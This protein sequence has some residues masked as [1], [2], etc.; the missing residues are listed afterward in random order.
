MQIV[1]MNAANAHEYAPSPARTFW[2]SVGS[3]TL[4]PKR[5]T[6]V[7]YGS[8]MG[9]ALLLAGKLSYGR[10]EGVEFASDLNAIASQ[11]IATTFPAPEDRARFRLHTLDATDYR[12]PLEPCVIY[13]FNP[14]GPM[15][16][17]RI[18]DI[19]LDS[20][21]Q[22]PRE[23]YVVY[24]NPQNKASFERPEFQ[25]VEGAWYAKYL[26]RRVPSGFAIYRLHAAPA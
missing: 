4:D 26:D 11:N 7:D 13:L 5:F 22:A 2:L 8:G 25:P 19:I 6:F 3:L 10:I 1:G 14:F 16:V 9:R 17:E 18:A 23:I 20:Y 21:R 15:L 24:V 12:L